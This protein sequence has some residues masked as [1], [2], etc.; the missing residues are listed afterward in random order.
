MIDAIEHRFVEV[1]AMWRTAEGRS[2]WEQASGLLIDGRH[3]LTSQHA[4]PAGTLRITVRHLLPD[5][6]KQTWSATTRLT[7]D[8]GHAD[9]AL[10][11][12]DEDAGPLPPVGFARISGGGDRAATLDDCHAVGFPAFMERGKGTQRVRYQAHVSGRIPVF[13]IPGPGLRTLRTTHTPDQERL[14]ASGSTLAGTPWSGMSGAAVIAGGHVVGV[15][16][17][18]APRQGASDL[19]IVPITLIDNLPDAAAWWDVLGTSAD[20]LPMLPAAAKAHETAHVGRPL[21]EWKPVRDLQVSPAIRTADAPAD[22]LPYYVPRE[23]DRELRERLGQAKFEPVF[24]VLLGLPYVGKSRA[25]YEAVTEC[26]PDWRLFRP[27]HPDE[28]VAALRDRRIG[29]R[30]VIWLDDA[31]K[32]IFHGEA[33]GRAAAL[34][35]SF[36]YELDATHPRSVAVVAT[37]WTREWDRLRDRDISPATSAL[38][39][40]DLAI[41]VQKDFSSAD[42]VAVRQAAEHDSRIRQAIEAEGESGELALHLAGG[43][44]QVE[45]FRTAG[46]VPKA[47]IRA[48]LDA[49]QVGVKSPLDTEFLR[50]AV[51]G[52]LTARELLGWQDAFEAY[53]ARILRPSD[54]PGA[55]QPV[56]V[57]EPTDGPPL[58]HPADYLVY[59]YEDHRDAPISP[60]L[61]DVLR[62]WATENSDRD[63]IALDAGLRGYRRLSTLFWSTAA[64]GSPRPVSKYAREKIDQMAR[65]PPAYFAEDVPNLRHPWPAPADDDWVF[66]I[67]YNAAMTA[68][69]MISVFSPTAAVW[70]FLVAGVL[71]LAIRY[72]FL[73]NP[74]TQAGLLRRS[75]ALW[76]L[77]YRWAERGG[78]VA[79][80]KAVEAARAAVHGSKPRRAPGAEED[81]VDFADVPHRLRLACLEESL[82]GHERAVALFPPEEPVADLCLDSRPSDLPVDLAWRRG[83]PPDVLLRAGRPAA[84]LDWLRRASSAQWD[85]KVQIAIMEL[86]CRL[87]RIEELVGCVEEFPPPDHRV[88]ADVVSRLIAH[89]EHAKAVQWLCPREDRWFGASVPARTAIMSLVAHLEEIGETASAAELL[90]AHLPEP[91][92]YRRTSAPDGSYR[93][94]LALLLAGAGATEEAARLYSPPA[95]ADGSTVVDVVSEHLIYLARLGDRVGMS[96]LFDRTCAE[97]DE[98]SALDVLLEDLTVAFVG[99][100]AIID[101]ATASK[102]IDGWPTRWRIDVLER[103]GEYGKARMII[104]RSMDLL[105]F[106]TRE[107]FRGE[108]IRVTYLSGARHEAGLIYA[109]GSEPGGL[110]TIPWHPTSTAPDLSADLPEQ[111]SY[112]LQGYVESDWI[113]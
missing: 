40:P 42:F 99:A 55:L 94:R 18:H 33:G 97:L 2:R 12:L 45:Q 19:T 51:P 95:D 15:V 93:L 84:A 8:P 58:F 17:E 23:H 28:L 37:M 65:F 111:A 102:I 85:P 21:G 48:V 113:R 60:E 5:G 109:F 72:V 67:A 13:Q 112:V 87:E 9:L 35:R 20:A 30:T 83:S 101:R 70:L 104:E 82:G 78:A 92:H 11:A 27:L 49:G 80:R 26:F 10:L 59:H 52:Y 14:P 4:I 29:P 91:S 107:L 41:D 47:I 3:V 6:T 100:R 34:L 89:G 31:A 105:S 66:P 50:R 1:L 110:P 71:Y 106:S 73:S 74:W 76:E 61:W 39:S 53:I 25:A 57:R 38:L 88:T 62:E 75:S 22:A 68:F 77:S 46:P 79:E 56:P 24:V 44:V 36:L 108:L 43:I 69:A 64:D 16:S 63:R 98:D 7:G 54:I 86:L 81:P 96:E 103:V 90:R 32:H